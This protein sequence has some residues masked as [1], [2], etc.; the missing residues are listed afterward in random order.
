MTLAVSVRIPDG[1]VLAV[2]SLSTVQG[3]LN[4][5]MDAGFKCQQCGKENQVKDMKLPPLP[6]PVSTKSAAQ[7]IVK[8][9]DSFGAA[10]FG[11]TFVNRKSMLSQI[12]TLESRLSGTVAEVDEAADI[13][14]NHF[15]TELKEEVKD[16]SQIPDNAIPFG[17]Q[18]VGFDAAGRGKTWVIQMG[19]T[20]KKWAESELGMTT[21]GDLALVQKLLRQDLGFPTAQPN[22]LTFSLQD[23]VDY[24]KFLIRFVADYQRF[25]N[26][27]P[28]VGGDIDVALVTSYAGF[29]WIERKRISAM[30]ED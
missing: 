4:L 10:F 5:K 16:L 20:P 25:A 8:F 19:K 17:L 24:A 27:I 11:S 6:Y 3:S 22:L 1:V 9:R 2:D 7:K 18:V 15:V 14:F 26:M 29:R 23:A 30:L 28:T 13:I 21:S 12:K